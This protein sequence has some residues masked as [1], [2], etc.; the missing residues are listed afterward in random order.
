MLTEKWREQH[1]QAEKIAK[2]AEIRG[3]ER[4]DRRRRETREKTKNI[5]N[6]SESSILRV[7]TG[8]EIKREISGTAELH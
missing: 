3:G 6:V 8:P 5:I 1:K 4:S 2:G 7:E